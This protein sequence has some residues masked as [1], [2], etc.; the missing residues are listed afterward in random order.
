[1]NDY[2]TSV[3]FI[4]RAGAGCHPRLGDGAVMAAVNYQFTGG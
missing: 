2:K 4:L 1:M 3:A